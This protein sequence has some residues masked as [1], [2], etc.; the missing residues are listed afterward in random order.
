MVCR[1]IFFIT[2][3]FCATSK[4]QTNSFEEKKGNGKKNGQYVDHWENGEKREAGYYDNGLKVGEWKKW[5]RK[6]ELQN[7]DHYVDGVLHGPFTFWQRGTNPTPGKFKTDTTLKDY[8][9]DIYKYEG[10]H[11]HGKVDST[12]TI[13]YENGNK[14]SEAR[15][16]NGKL[17]G[18]WKEW[19]DNGKMNY[20]AEYDT[21]GQKN[22]TVF[23][24]YPNGQM[25]SSQTNYIDR[26]DPRKQISHGTW[27][28]W[29][30]NG[31]QQSES[32]YNQGIIEGK[33]I[34]W[35]KNGQKKYEGLYEKNRLVPGSW[36][37][38]DSNGN[39]IKD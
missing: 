3:L 35:Y 12:Y 24:Y 20:Q 19:Y 7:I 28:L 21:I 17:V 9:F 6:G 29:Y 25:K 2:V 1:L 14:K 11:K 34:G 22:R 36:K 39:L 13:W 26:S 16:E 33:W 8:I 10:Y 27:K 18:I 30:E 15:Y 31:Q 37:D 5:S 32:N 23:D 4:A 38:W